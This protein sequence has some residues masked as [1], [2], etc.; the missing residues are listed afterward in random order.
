MTKTLK[1]TATGLTGKKWIKRLEKGGYEVSEYAKSILL[2]PEFDEAVHSKGIEYTVGIVPQTELGLGKYVSTAEIKSYAKSKGW[3]MPTL[4]I[5]LLVR[6][7]LSDEDIEA[8]GVWYV[9]ALHEPIKD[10]GGGP[11]VLGARRDDGGRWLYAFWGNPVGQW[12]TDGAF[13][14]LVPASTSGSEAQPSSETLDLAA[15][16]AKIEAILAHHN[17]HD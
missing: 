1:L 17:L 4:E 7:A 10:S 6:E 11:S 9:A 15:R 13:A 16:V 3:L 14:F 12:R 5:A 8:L 2:S